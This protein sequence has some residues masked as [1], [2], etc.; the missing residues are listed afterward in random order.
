[1]I[2]LPQLTTRS[3]RRQLSIARPTSRKCSVKDCPLNT[4]SCP[5]YLTGILGYCQHTAFNSNTEYTHIYTRC[6]MY[7]RPRI[8]TASVSI[9]NLQSAPGDHLR[10]L[11][12]RLVVNLRRPSRFYIIEQWCLDSPP[13]AVSAY[14]TSPVICCRQIAAS[15]N[16]PVP[17]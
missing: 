17:R 5:P 12:L 16:C 10:I 9:L 13:E 8:N 14:E 3:L 2:C 1:V 11:S 4:T 7:T 6:V 15:G